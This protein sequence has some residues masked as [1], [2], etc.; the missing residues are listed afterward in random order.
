MKKN[1]QSAQG[2]GKSNDIPTEVPEPDQ[3]ASGVP[4]TGLENITY[5]GMRGNMILFL[6]DRQD[7]IVK[8][9]NT[10]IERLEEW[11]TL[12]EERKELEERKQAK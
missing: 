3:I 4:L 2:S 10:K 8:R 5:S 12:I 1:L 6:A 7:R 11:L 9:L